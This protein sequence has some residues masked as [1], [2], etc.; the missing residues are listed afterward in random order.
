[1]I[2]A[3]N[4]LGNTYWKKK[5]MKAASNCFRRALEQQ[6]NKESLRRL[7]VVLRSMATDAKDDEAK[8]R[9]E[10]LDCAK[11]AIAMDAKDGES[12]Y[13]MG[14]AYLTNYF[15]ACRDFSDM[16]KA[17]KAYDRAGV[18]QQGNPDLY[19]NR[20][21][22][23][24]FREDYALAMKDFGHA[25]LLDPSL[26]CDDQMEF[27]QRFTK[28]VSKQIKSKHQLKKKAR[29]AMLKRL[30][31]LQTSDYKSAELSDLVDGSNPSVTFSGI[32]VAPVSRRESDA[33]PVS[34]LVLGKSD[35][36]VMVS[37]Y[38]V[39][40]KLLDSIKMQFD[41]ITIVQPL[42]RQV[43]LDGVD[44]F[45]VVQVFLPSFIHVNGKQL[46]SAAFARTEVQIHAM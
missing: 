25:K 12:W 31:P 44:P 18:S 3:W 16:E 10:S 40:T 7:S 19:Y 22:V 13:I 34:F 1:M 32:V 33:V 21:C 30:Q 37:L 9:K 23:H 46:H 24:Q 43:Q 41:T 36:M 11:Q 38:N 6:K 39:T 17:L 14:N 15:S 45:P 27:M 42:L 26:P 29:T 28:R 2:E 5:E 8:L 20:G 35:Q 4:A